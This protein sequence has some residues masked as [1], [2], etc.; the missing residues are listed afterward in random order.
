[1]LLLSC[2]S[3]EKRKR[4]KK[5][6]L[7]KAMLCT[8]GL[9]TQQHN[10]SYSFSFSWYFPCWVL[11]EEG[12]FGRQQHFSFFSFF[13]QRFSDFKLKESGWCTT[14]R[15]NISAPRPRTLSA[16]GTQTW[17]VFVRVCWCQLQ[18]NF[19]STSKGN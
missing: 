6:S 17:G 14:R 12:S 19:E 15:G 13:D 9:N 8:L 18:E 16:A 2:T 11:R 1:M 4:R 3:S 7:S 5:R 10:P